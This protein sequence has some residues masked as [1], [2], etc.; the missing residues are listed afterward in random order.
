[1]HLVN[2]VFE[3]VYLLVQVGALYLSDAASNDWPRMLVGEATFESRMPFPEQRR[4]QQSS[5]ARY[6][7][8]K[9]QGGS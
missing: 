6:A 8:H 5:K 3:F 9:V 4:Y 1:M 7:L 2:G